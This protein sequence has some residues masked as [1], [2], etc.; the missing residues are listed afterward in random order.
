MTATDRVSGQLVDL[1]KNSIYPA[2]IEIEDGKISKITEEREAP[3][4]YLT[5]GLVDA[6]VHIESSLLIPR[7]FARLAV[8]HGTV[9]TV[10]D[11]HEIANVLGIEGI[12]FMLDD[13]AAVPFKFA[14]GAPSCV[15]ATTF[16][17]AGHEISSAE[18][19]Q[20]LS[21]EEIPYLSEMMNFPGVLDGLPEVLQ[22]LSTAKKLGKPIDG[23]APGLRG[24]A[25]KSYFEAGITTDHEC[26][27]YEEAKEKLS[28]GVKILI[29]EGSAAKNFEALIPLLKEAPNMIMFCSDDKH[30]DSLIESH[31]DDHIRRALA[32]GC[33][34]FDTL[35]AASRNPIEHYSLPIGQLRVGDPADF[36]VVSDL[37][38]F[39]VRSTYI[40]GERVASEGESLLS[41]SLSKQQ[42][43]QF[44]RTPL[45]LEQLERKGREGPLRVI[46]AIPGE[47]VTEEEQQAAAFSDGLL[48]SDPSRDLLKLAVVNRYDSAAPPAIAFVSGFGLK[49]GAL[50]SSVAHDSHNIVAVGASDEELLL[51]IN[52]LV[53][54]KGGL[55]AVSEGETSLLPL[56][57]AGL[58]SPAEGY[59]T[60]RNYI[61]LDAKARALGSTLPSPF[62]TLSF[63]ALL[64]IP[65]L[66]LSDKGLFNGEI[67]SFVELQPDK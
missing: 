29:R 53:E 23:H 36:L 60:A 41:H 14:F 28:L 10:S 12:E 17:T 56:P 52:T 18:I 40:N 19:E 13:A 27:S 43:N 42:P 1:H 44:S 50:A 66:K 6:H 25:A 21:R 5:P 67:F 20:L 35:R 55:A 63:L 8:V 32:L 31:I 54:A 62:M 58:M 59:E 38:T 61:S 30:P 33:D 16:E 11:P 65:K 26:F 57:V 4:H 46:R 45:H 39:K 9:G 24:E 3:Q 49:H 2:T 64:V 37:E 34:L 48:L 15:P 7:E 22:K 47:L 51:A